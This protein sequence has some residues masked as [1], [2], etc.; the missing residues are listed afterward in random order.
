M[1]R[2]ITIC[3]ILTGIL[4]G[5]KSSKSHCDSYGDLENQDKITTT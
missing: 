5:C 3:L 4:L 2:K 1:V